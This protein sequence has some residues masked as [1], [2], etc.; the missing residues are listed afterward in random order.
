MVQ[1]GDRL[2]RKKLIEAFCPP[3]F[4]FDPAFRAA[5]FPCAM[6]FR[7]EQIIF[8]GDRHFRAECTSPVPSLTGDLVARNVFVVV[9]LSRLLEYTTL[10]VMP[11]S[12]KASECPAGR[13]TSSSPQ[14]GHFRCTVLFKPTT[15]RRGD[16]LHGSMSRFS[17][18]HQKRK[19]AEPRDWSPSDTARHQ[20]FKADPLG[21]ESA[22]RLAACLRVAI[23]MRQLQAWP[24]PPYRFAT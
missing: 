2:G 22:F 15:R 23:P 14:L 8:I 21:R 17:P 18:S 24:S 13:P 5:Q 19:V 3:C 20:L 1:H 4:F 16:M 7:G 10:E 11:H 12:H 9:C 6:T